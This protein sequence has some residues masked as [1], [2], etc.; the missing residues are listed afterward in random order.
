MTDR[1][2]DLLKALP[3]ADPGPAFTKAV[4]AALPAPR[5]ELHHGRWMAT[6][7]TA[8]VL[9]LIADGSDAGPTL[10]RARETVATWGAL[11][12]AFR[13]EVLAQGGAVPWPLVTRS[14]YASAAG[15]MITWGLAS[16]P[17]TGSLALIRRR[18]A[19]R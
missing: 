10:L 7:L 13:G 6:I 15:L 9:L 16:L 18:F 19:R 3:V 2:D 14:L 11:V 8:I 17:L 12:Q 4:M 5:P 1:V